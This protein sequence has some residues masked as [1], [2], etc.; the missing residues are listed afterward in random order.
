M[1]KGFVLS[2]LLVATVA[3]PLCAQG[4]LSNEDLLER[5]LRA[6]LAAGAPG[7]PKDSLLAAIVALR[8]LCYT[9]IRR[10]E[11]VRLQQV[12]RRFGL[13]DARLTASER[14]SLDRE[15]D[16]ARRQLAQEIAMAVSN[17]TG[18]AG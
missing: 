8:S 13:P 5:R 10:V 7:A 3:T 11:E 6:C 9:Q 17:F 12:D 14:D 2:G 16:L 15:R 4:G 18:L 1:L